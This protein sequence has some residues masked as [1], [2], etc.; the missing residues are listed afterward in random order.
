M[1]RESCYY[2]YSKR[3]PLVCREK[4]TIA[5]VVRGGQLYV[6]RTRQLQV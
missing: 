1:S 5:S 2:K 3:Q 4:V 6:A